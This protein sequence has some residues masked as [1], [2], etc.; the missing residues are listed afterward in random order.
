LAGLL[1][2]SV[3]YLRLSPAGRAHADATRAHLNR[4]GEAGL[5]T[6]ALAYR[7][8]SDSEYEAW[9]REHTAARTSLDS[10]R[11]AKLDAAAELI[12]N[13][14]TLLGATAVEDKLQAGVRALPRQ[15]LHLAN[16]GSLQMGCS[17]N[18]DAMRGPVILGC[19]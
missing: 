9:E 17:S 18:M 16:R 7:K 8:L 12:E 14:L 15:Q 5:R 4:Y 19:I 1:P 13:G 6:L 11:E 2:C 10:D 3:I